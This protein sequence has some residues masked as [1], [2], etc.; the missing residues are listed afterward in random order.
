[1][2]MKYANRY[3]DRG[4]LPFEVVDPVSPSEL[5]VREMSCERLQ[6]WTPRFVMGHCLNE[7]EQRWDIT[8]DLE[9]LPFRIRKNKQGE[10]LDVS[11][12]VYRLADI[13]VRF[14]RFSFVGG[15]YHADGDE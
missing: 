2:T 14:H 7:S 8:S 10:W 13:P 5:V 9:A 1:M 4:A 12:N 3:T 6:G 11:G 15:V